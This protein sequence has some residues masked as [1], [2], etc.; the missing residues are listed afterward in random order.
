MLFMKKLTICLYFLCLCFSQ[1]KIN[2][3]EIEFSGYGAVGY[4]FANKNLLNGFPQESYFEGKLQSDVK[5]NKD[6]D[7]QLDLRA[8]SFESAF[9]LKELYIKIDLGHNIK[10]K[11]GNFKKPFGYEQL[12]N[13]EELISIE[14]SIISDNF[15]EMGFGGRDISLMVYNKYDNKNADDMPLSYYMSV[16]KNNSLAVSLTG[17]LVYHIGEISLAGNY[18]YINQGGEV[19]TNSSGFGFDVALENQDYKLFSEINYI[20]NKEVNIYLKTAGFEDDIYSFAAKLGA[21]YEF[22]FDTGFIKKI[23]PL[24]VAGVLLPD[25]KVSDNK[26]IQTILGVNFYIHKKVA[27]RLNGDLRLTKNEF[28]NSYTTQ[29]SRGIIEIIARF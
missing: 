14:R 4:R 11:A 17:R 1:I 27:I 18:M 28:S 6:I 29:N 26:Q 16:S 13:K 9:K 24:L 19:T 21:S 5:I 2:N 7:L 12:L 22:K 15:S 23:E 25:A 10:L 20:A 8:N 3:T